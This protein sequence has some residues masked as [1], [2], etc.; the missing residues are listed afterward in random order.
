M[1]DNT[2]RRPIDWKFGACTDVGTVRSVNEDAVFTKGE[3]G[4]WAVA[5]GMGGHKIGD[6]ASK[7]IVE[8]LDSVVSHEHLADFVDAVDQK[9]IDVN[10]QIIDL[11]L[12]HI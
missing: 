10:R 8:A 2:F 3:I 7:M 11:S 9:L 6:I 12:I 5:D 4:L 1:I